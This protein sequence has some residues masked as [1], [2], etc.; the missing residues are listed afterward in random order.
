MAL[1]H[2]IHKVKKA[3]RIV[4]AHEQINHANEYQQYPAHTERKTSPT[5]EKARQQLIHVDMHPCFFCGDTLEDAHA[6]G[7]TLESHH[8]FEFSLWEKLDPAK[9]LHDLRKLDFHGY[10]CN[11]API[12][13]PDDIRNQVVICSCCHREDGYGIHH[14]TIPFVWARR[15]LKDK[16]DDVLR[17]YKPLKPNKKLQEQAVKH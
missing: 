11:D 7:Y 5:F 1:K 8:W 15:A 13:T 3:L 2:I 14:A 4:P 9:V 6:K 10:G 17:R 12:T 16:K